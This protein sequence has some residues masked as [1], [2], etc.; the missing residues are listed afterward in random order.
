MQVSQIF[1]SDTDTEL[2]PFLQ[3]ATGT[4]QSAFPQANYTIYNKE[5]LREFIEQNYPAEVIW[6]YDT[7]KPYS[8]K[9]DLGRF[10]LLNKLGG[11]YFDIGVRA[12]SPVQI[13]DRI[14]FLAFRDIQRFSFTSWACAT[15]V[16]YSKP[17]NPALVTAIEMIINNCHEQ[18][19]GI[20]PLCPTGP[21]LLGKAL[22]ANGSQSNFVYGDY[23][24]LTPTHEQKNRA[25]VLPDGTIMAWSK[26]SGGGDLSALGAQGTNNYNQLWH[27]QQIYDSSIR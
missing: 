12:H 7:L 22:A 27:T 4:V 6:A 20:T 5:T 13:G 24:E 25:F 23:L 9:A 1:L 11:W 26:P 8:Y 21:T 10:C 3:Y 2:S 19:Y 18:Y 17:D 15:T 16:L 14:E